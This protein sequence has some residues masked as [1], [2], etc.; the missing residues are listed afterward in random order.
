MDHDERNEDAPI[1]AV[2]APLNRRVPL[3]WAL[4]AAALGS[5]IAAG[6][7]VM[8]RVER[9]PRPPFLTAPAATSTSR[10]RSIPPAS[11]DA[12][13]FAGSG[14]NLP[15]TQV[16]VEAYRVRNPHTRMVV[17]ESI[18]SSG[19][20]R[21]LRDGAINISL[22]SRP[23]TEEET[24]AGLR[25]LSYARVA[26]VIATNPSVPDACTSREHFVHLYG[27]TKAKWIDGSRAVILQRERG[28]SSFQVFANLVPGLAEENE[29]AYRED[30]WRVLYS[31]RA[32]QEA[33]MSTE[34]AAG[35]FD[36]GAITVHR[37][38]LKVMCVDGVTPS[39]WSVRT[40]RYP[41][42]K[43][44]SFVTAGP[45]SKLASAFF[46]FVQ[47]PEGRALTEASG[48]LALP[49]DQDKADAGAKGGEPW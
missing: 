33:L 5:L 38:P 21:A 36:L 45:P 30:R 37:L 27:R 7:L 11:E 1:E 35:I 29:A 4:V 42:W 34:G 17:H 14:S 39:L 20:I 26:V 6:T 10:L 47:S 22:V 12:L 19:G 43:D 18:G 46:E 15:L 23:L 8:L 32:M 25:A 13:I 2:T 9:G 48:H 40:G 16:L 24:R 44:L 41:F 49:V 3:L 31:D 28:D